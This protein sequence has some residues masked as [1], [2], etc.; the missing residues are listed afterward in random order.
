MIYLT[1]INKAP[2]H[3][4][5]SLTPPPRKLHLAAAH[6]YFTALHAS[7]KLGPHTV[8]SRVYEKTFLNVPN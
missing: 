3:L 8:I 1:D 6:F 5:E 4:P 2:E 7:S